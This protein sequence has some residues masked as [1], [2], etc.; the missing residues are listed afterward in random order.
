MVE[1]A[2]GVDLMKNTVMPRPSDCSFNGAG[3][4]A[5]I[6]LTGYEHERQAD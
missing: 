1:I 4:R 3:S 6:S 5:S 2:G